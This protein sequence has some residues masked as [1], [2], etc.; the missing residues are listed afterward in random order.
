MAEALELKQ[1]LSTRCDRFV[2]LFDNKKTLPLQFIAALRTTHFKEFTAAFQAP[3]LDSRLGTS[4][5][6]VH[7]MRVDVV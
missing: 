6:L 1:A 5:V 2:S 4:Q 7:R 3:Y